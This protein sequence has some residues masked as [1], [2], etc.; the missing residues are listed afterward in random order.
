MI[1]LDRIL[2]PVD[3]SEQSAEAL[4]HGLALA[5][6]YR[7]RATVFHAYMDVQPPVTAAALPGGAAMAM[8]VS[9]REE[10]LATLRRFSAAAGAAPGEVEVVVSAGAPAAA[11]ARAAAELRADLIVMGTHGGSAVAR[12][13]LGSV[14]EKVLR[15]TDAPVLTI[16]PAAT[17]AAAPRYQTILCALDFS[18]ASRRALEYALLLAQQDQARLVLLHAIEGL[19]DDVRMTEASHFTVPEYVRYRTEDAAARIE[20]AI[21]DDARQ[22]CRP[23]VRI[24]PGAASRHLVGAAIELPADIVVLGVHGRSVMERFL[25]GSTA[26]HVIRRAPCPVLTLRG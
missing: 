7:A 5:R 17:P 10:V 24:V 20:A 12:V 23:E 11:I 22:W 13:L 16:P 25:F 4:R 9:S 8:P 15:T 2:C 18:D 19:L 1:Q 26:D 14:T 3:L 21:P 6:L